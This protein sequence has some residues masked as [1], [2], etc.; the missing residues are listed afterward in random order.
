MEWIIES[1]SDVYF[2]MIL[3]FMTAAMVVCFL[4][5]YVLGMNAVEIDEEQAHGS[6]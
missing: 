2:L 6:N 1:F 3:G 5:G 4:W